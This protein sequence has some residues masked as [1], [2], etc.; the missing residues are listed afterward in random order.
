MWEDTEVPAEDGGR[1]PGGPRGLAPQEHH[2]VL[3]PSGSL[4]DRARAVLRSR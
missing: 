3:G 1:V 2:E 4:V